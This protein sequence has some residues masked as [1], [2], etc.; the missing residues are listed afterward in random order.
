ME[1]R[2]VGGG[3]SPLEAAERGSLGRSP[4]LPAAIPPPFCQPGGG[5]EGQLGAPV[6]GS[7]PWDPG[8]QPQLGRPGCPQGLGS[9]LGE[10]CGSQVGPRPS[11]AGQEPPPTAGE[12]PPG[13][14]VRAPGQGFV[15]A[16]RTRGRKSYESMDSDFFGTKK[17]W[18]GKANSRFTRSKRIVTTTTTSAG[19]LGKRG[20]A[21]A[22]RPRVKMGSHFGLKRLFPS[23]ALAS[24]G[25]PLDEGA[26]G[27]AS[28]GVPSSPLR[29]G[30]EPLLGSSLGPADFGLDEVDGLAGRLVRRRPAVAFKDQERIVIEINDS[31]SEND[32]VGF[33]N[34]FWEKPA[35][36]FAN[37]KLS[38]P[39]NQ[40]GKSS[41]ESRDGKSREDRPT[42]TTRFAGEYDQ[43][44]LPCKVS[45]HAFGFTQ[46]TSG[47]SLF[48][49]TPD[50]DGRTIEGQG[51][52]GLGSAASMAESSTQASGVPQVG[53]G[54]FTNF[55]RGDPFSFGPKPRRTIY[56]YGPMRAKSVGQPGYFPP[57]V[58]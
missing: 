37:R 24:P 1:A 16:F 5:R 3:V 17:E 46:R 55:K 58:S 33:A 13:A 22:V 52:K 36:T 44:S 51:T 42:F 45:R 10:G 35:R 26:P 34:K 30:L 14:L 7:L 41:R 49:C 56:I 8:C 25:A 21:F 29:V 40:F 48:T 28:L 39:S 57:R 38:W 54:N 47:P 6:S 50:A 18:G 31:D 53:F 9:S 4:P 11:I 19:Q 43:T 2:G 27:D 23:R 12:G 20:F 15:K 32:V